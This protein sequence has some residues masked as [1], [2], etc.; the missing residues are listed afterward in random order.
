MVKNE[1]SRLSNLNKKL[2]IFWAVFL[3]GEAVEVDVQIYFHG[4]ATKAGREFF[5]LQ[6]SL[7][8]MVP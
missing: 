1:N 7:L 5:A 8:A 4:Y 2:P 3:L 6:I